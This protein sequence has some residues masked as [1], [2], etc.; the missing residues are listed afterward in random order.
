M[1]MKNCCGNITVLKTV[2]DRPV[3]SGTESQFGPVKTPKTGQQSVKNRKT[4]KKSSKN[5]G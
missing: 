1:L 5:R 4:G 3:R 2:P